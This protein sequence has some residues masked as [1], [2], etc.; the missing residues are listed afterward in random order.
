MVL[1]A[2]GAEEHRAMLRLA[3]GGFRDMTRIASGHP[4]IWPDICA[5][6]RDAIVSSLLELEAALAN[7]RSMVER[8]DRDALLST[9][10]RARAARVNLPARVAAIADM[11]EVRVPVPDRPGVIAEI[12]TLASE[13]GVN[14]ADFETAHSSEGDAGV[15]LLLV[16]VDAVERFTG[17]L[18][19]RGYRNSWRPLV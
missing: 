1:A 15:L 7:V 16:P 4:G 5:E 3:A 9:L 13:L 18:M 19:A 8:G 2:E 10:E 12:T 6:N 14:I 11:A 17:G